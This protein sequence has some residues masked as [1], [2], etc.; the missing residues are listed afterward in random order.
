VDTG[1]AYK[2]KESYLSNRY[3]RVVI[4][5]HKYSNRHFSKWEEV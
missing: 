1:V 4:N 3:Q 2:L 5:A